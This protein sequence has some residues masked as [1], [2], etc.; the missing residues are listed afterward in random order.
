M[1]R[2]LSTLASLA[3]LAAAAAAGQ[4]WMDASLPPAARAA[5][6]LKEMTQVIPPAL[7]PVPRP[8]YP[9]PCLPLWLCPLALPCP[10][11]C[12][13][14]LFSPSASCP[15]SQQQRRGTRAPFCRCQPHNQV[16]LASSTPLVPGGLPT[17]VTSAASLLGGAISHVSSFFSSSLPSPFQ[18]EKLV[19]LH[20]PDREAKTVA[21]NYVG[22]V[23]PAPMPPI[24][25]TSLALQ[26][27]S[28]QAWERGVSKLSVLGLARNVPA[29]DRL[30]IPPLNLNDGARSPVCVCV[31]ARVCAVCVCVWAVVAHRTRRTSSGGSARR[32][33]PRPQARRASG[34]TRTRARP[35]PGRPVFPVTCLSLSIPLNTSRSR[36]EWSD[37]FQ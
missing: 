1:M 37:R 2:S 13:R 28:Q 27:A 20:G 19:M 32:P 11:P 24:C 15:F 30:K 3:S 17:C 31:R 16:M 8:L 25:R 35:Q 36:L 12:C 29:N 4:P 6:L 14:L 26:Q 33:P 10:S 34:T 18:E 22:N 5:A 9:L 21:E 23:V 7:L